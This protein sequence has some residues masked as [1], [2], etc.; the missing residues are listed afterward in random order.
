MCFHGEQRKIKQKGFSWENFVS[1]LLSRY[2][3]GFVTRTS[4]CRNCAGNVIVSS[5]LLLITFLI[6]ETYWADARETHISKLALNDIGVIVGVSQRSNFD[7]NHN[8]TACIPSGHS[9]HGS[10]RTV[11]YSTRNWNTVLILGSP[12]CESSNVT[13]SRDE[14]E[15]TQTR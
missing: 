10:R 7:C 3:H 11:Q 1:F 13:L 5:S 8:V 12:S 14:I 9:Y 4:R 2:M 6:R 15:T